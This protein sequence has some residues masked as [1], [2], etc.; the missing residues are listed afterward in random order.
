ML[1]TSTG[2]QNQRRSSSQ[3]I[4]LLMLLALIIFIAITGFVF[5]EAA[6]SAFSKPSAITSPMTIT[7]A[8]G[9]TIQQLS[10]DLAA[11]SQVPS[12]FWLKLYV[13]L[14]P[15]EGYL[16]AGNY[17][18]PAHSTIRQI[19]LQLHT[20]TPQSTL[21][22]TEGATIND[23]ATDISANTSLNITKAQVI[24]AEQQLATSYDFLAQSAPHPATLE[25]YL[26]PDTYFIS[27]DATPT[28]I[29]QKM[30]DNESQKVTP[31]MLAEIQSKNMTLNQAITVASLIEKEIGTTGAARDPQIVQQER[32]TVAGIIYN[33]LNKGMALQLDSTKLYIQ[34]GQPQPDPS[35][36][37]YVISGLPP[38]PISNPSLNSIEAAI[39]PIQSD[40]LYFIT[41]KNGTAHF[42]KTIQEQDANIA[43]YLK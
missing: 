9:E 14:H 10:A 32:Q 2:F 23:I 18:V 31:T 35:Y 4:L 34:P 24:A 3:L 17:V 19:V 37:T 12:A 25:G 28:Q 8:S 33:R 13:R 21:R 39:N 5:V 6:R 16:H 15:T 7:V 11:K 27:A 38:G 29:L 30:L 36:N 42:A 20:V 40:Y 1:E 43:Q 22:I 26:F 41:D